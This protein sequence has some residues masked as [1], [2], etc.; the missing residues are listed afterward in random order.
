VTSP[1]TSVSQSLLELRIG[2]KFVPRPNSVQTEFGTKIVPSGTLGRV[3]VA[4]SLFTHLTFSQ[5]RA[6][7]RATAPHRAAISIA[8]RLAKAVVS[9]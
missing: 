6:T 1:E 8:I 3:R 9:R 7:A 4:S 2:T 5:P